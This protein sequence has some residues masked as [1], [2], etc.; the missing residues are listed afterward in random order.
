MESSKPGTG[1]MGYEH[2]TPI[3]EEL[4]GGKLVDKLQAHRPLVALAPQCSQPI[5]AAED[6]VDA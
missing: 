2:A 5:R 3:E 6:E 4:A 1:M